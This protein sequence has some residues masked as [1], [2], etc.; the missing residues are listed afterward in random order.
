MSRILL[1]LESNHQDWL[2][3]HLG[4]QYQ[5][6][7]AN[8]TA[9]GMATFDLCILDE[10]ALDRFWPLLQARKVGAE[11]AFLPMLLVVTQSLDPKAIA[12]RDRCGVNTSSIPLEQL[13]HKV[14]D[15]IISPIAT[16]ELLLRVEGLL[17]RRRLSL[18]VIKLKALVKE[19]TSQSRDDIK[20]SGKISPPLFQIPDLK[21]DPIH[22][23]IKESSYLDSL[24]N[25]MPDIVCFKDGEGRWLEANQA[26]LEL[27]ELD[28]ADYCG[29]KDSELGELSSFYREAF[30]I[31]ES[32][33]RE[34]WIKKTLSRGEEV[35]ARS[36]GSVKIYDV[37]K[38]PLFYPNGERK[39][40]V[41][42]GRDITERKQAEDE[43]M[44]LASIVESSDDAI[45]GKTPEGI[46]LSWNAGAEQIYG[47]TAAEV[48]GLGIS[49]LAMPDRQGEMPQI[50]ASIRAGTGIDHYETVHQRKDGKPI[51]VSLTIS[52]I[53]DKAGAVVGVSTIARDISDRKRVEMALEQLRHQNE[54]ILHSAGE[55]IC[56]LNRYGKITFVNP[57]AAKMTGY[58]V[59]ELIDRPLYQSLSHSQVGKIPYASQNCQIL[60]TLEDGIARHVTNEMFWRRDG[61]SFPVEYVAG[62]IC[63]R[64]EIIGAVVTF[65]D[66]TDRLAVEKMKD[67]FISVIS[68]EL[69]TPL[70]S[71]HG[72]LRLL[73][74]GLLD[75][76]SQRGKRMLEIAVTNT[77]RLVRLI[78][79]ILDLERMES[80]YSNRELQ[81]CNA[82]EL[83]VQAGDEMRAMAEKAGVTLSV[84][85][86]AALLWAIPDRLIQALTNLLSNAIKFSQPGATIWLTGE[87]RA[88]KESVSTSVT[89]TEKVCCGGKQAIAPHSMTLN[90]ANSAN[91][92]SEINLPEALGGTSRSLKTASPREELSN[93]SSCSKHNWEVLIAV[94]DRGR[95]IPADKLE[96]IFER[97]QQVDASDS[98]QKG[99][100]GLGLAIC[101]SILQ[102]HGGRIWAE[103]VLGEG[104]T[105]FLTLPVV[106]DGEGF[107]APT[108]SL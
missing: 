24:I 94:K 17:A 57:A 31:C 60:A 32:T 68:H 51:D 36:D 82:A 47:Y 46:I 49:I 4:T 10:A 59:K 66:I 1:L 3:L 76:Q 69:R 105:F 42:L 33:D 26:M 19:S 22:A 25:A 104:S 98:R 6:L 9:N 93:L 101:R 50:L 43:L 86:I 67:E 29:L 40:I 52:P 103:S 81:T 79:D 58:E 71:I 21:S 88:V 55:G 100:T 106:T 27:F 72:A 83:M 102:Q 39:A 41:I 97:F 91:L 38:V 30:L 54:L 56:G 15:V 90:D 99:G 75:P 95:G 45:V 7:L 11:P 20:D 80:K 92:A 5:V 84:Q 48:K 78:N 62:P 96:T 8:E 16:V 37:I 74:S 44:R 77:D 61:T 85:P 35:I 63:D 107:D 108:R 65:K 14:D 2:A 13:R 28:R 18:E 64:E 87:V 23:P 53:K 70:T 73:A 12:R 89:I 34:A